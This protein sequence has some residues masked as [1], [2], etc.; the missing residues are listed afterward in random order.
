M[1]NCCILTGTACKEGT[2][3]YCY[4]KLAVYCLIL[5]PSHCLVFDHLHYAKTEGE[6]ILSCEL[7]LFPGLPWLQFLIACSNQKLEPGNEANVNHVSVYQCLS[8]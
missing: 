7:A 8:R 1:Y 5:S 2:A 3:S 4:A 6:G